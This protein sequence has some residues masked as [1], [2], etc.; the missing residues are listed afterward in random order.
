MAP[1]FKRLPNKLEF[2]Q[3]LKLARRSSS[4]F[5]NSTFEV[6]RDLRARFLRPEAPQ[7][8]TYALS[9]AHQPGR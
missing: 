5:S 2:E 9:S 7:I 1:A 6:E 8:G 4:T 3:Q